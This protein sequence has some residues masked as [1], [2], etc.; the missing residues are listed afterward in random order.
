M[1]LGSC[2]MALVVGG[3][4]VQRAAVFGGLRLGARLD[5]HG[6]RRSGRSRRRGRSA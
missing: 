4:D 2:A 5:L 6:L 1:K 3:I